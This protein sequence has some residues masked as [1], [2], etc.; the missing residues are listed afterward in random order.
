SANSLAAH[1]GAPWL[2]A[3]RCEVSESYP[4][5]ELDLA[6]PRRC[7][8]LSECST[9]HISRYARE[10]HSVKRIEEFARDLQLCC[11]PKTGKPER[12]G[13]PGVHVGIARP[14]EHISSQATWCPV[15][16]QREVRFRENALLE[17]SPGVR[18]VASEDWRIREV[19]VGAIRIKIAEGIG[20]AGVN[21][22]W[23]TVLKDYN[24]GE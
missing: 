14:C 16:R 21:R 5:A 1:A 13:D 3:D 18:D 12:L 2:T 6:W 20:L 8:R 7:G 22:E 10:V 11:L 15:R 9:R 24:I 19:I 23:Q 17:I 4:N